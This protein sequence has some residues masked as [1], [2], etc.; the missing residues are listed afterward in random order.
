M[1]IE[2]K[3]K[4]ERVEKSSFGMFTV[5]Q[6]RNLSR[7]KG[8]KPVPSCKDQPPQ[9]SIVTTRENTDLYVYFKYRTKLTYAY[10]YTCIYKYI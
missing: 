7:S 10:I 5:R 3:E 9:M 8:S 6:G 1:G 4:E 2:C